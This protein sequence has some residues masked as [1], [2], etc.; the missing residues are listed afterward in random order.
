MRE[1]RPRVRIA[2]VTGSR[3]EF[4]LLAPVMRAIREHPALDLITI[5]AGSH[6]LPPA[7]THREVEHEF[8]ID[9][10]VP[11]QD[12]DDPRLGAGCYLG[13]SADAAAV[14]RGV[15][16]FATI[17]DKL[18]PAWVVVLGDRIE[19]F[20][21]ATAAAVAGIP[22]AHIHGGDR[23][24]GIADES[25]RHAISKLAH[26]HLAASPQSALRL[27]RMGE[28]PEAVHVVGSPAIDGLG[29]IPVMCD[30]DARTLGDPL[31]VFLLHPSGLSDDREHAIATAAASAVAETVGRRVLWLA[32]NHDAGRASII[33]A[34]RS[35]AESHRWSCAEHLPRRSFISLLKRL[36]AMTSPSRG[37]LVG[38]SS[39]GLIEA[40]ALGV[41]TLNIGPR[42]NGRERPSNVTDA[43]EH[44][45][46]MLPVILRAALQR[47]LHPGPP[48]HPYGDGHAAERIAELLARAEPASDSV[49]RK[50]CTY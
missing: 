20:A 10:S 28:Q 37:V 48:L 1:H 14:G 30:A 47:T 3:A 44:E 18:E 19:A 25:M 39:A 50:R 45:L 13:R 17:F 8:P 6:Y 36:A 49:L 41:T 38:N 21:A 24:E 29:D 26:L 42:Q 5:A 4:G 12:P 11:M 35:V 16:G 27:L 7:F 34:V 22:L 31:A 15:C 9:A 46:S 43:A 40:A 33:R 2:V 23:A 32:P